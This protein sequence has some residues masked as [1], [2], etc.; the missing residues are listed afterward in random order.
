MHMSPEIP[1]MISMIYLID[2]SEIFKPESEVSECTRGILCGYSA[3]S[4]EEHF[5]VLTRNLTNG[6]KDRV[7]YRDVSILKNE[8]TK[9]WR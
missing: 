2:V 3:L 7:T 9:N 8:I 5:R 4:E 1:L 6:E